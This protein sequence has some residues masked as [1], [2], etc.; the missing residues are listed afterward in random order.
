MS[1]YIQK[2][3]VIYDIYLCFIKLEYIYVYLIDEVFMDVIDYLS[4]FQVLLYVLV[5]M[6]IYEIQVEIG[7]MVMVGIGVNFYLVKVV[8]D[9][10]VK[11][12]F[13]DVDGVWIVQMDEQ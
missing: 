8:M 13:V 12:I 4:I 3:V 5:K 6:M 9:I 2:S 11:K 10:V 1:Y 7:I